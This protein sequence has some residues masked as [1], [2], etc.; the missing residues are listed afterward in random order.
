MPLRPR[1]ILRHST[2]SDDLLLLSQEPG[3]RRHLR[4]EHPPDAR[5]DRQ[6]AEDEEDVRPGLD[7]GAGDVAH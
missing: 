4:H 7:L 1:H 5:E 3:L 2:H 6:Q